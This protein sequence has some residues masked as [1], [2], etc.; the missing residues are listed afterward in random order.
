MV[1]NTPAVAGLGVVARQQNGQIAEAELAEGLR[2]MRGK[3][4]TRPR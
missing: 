3:D 4:Q 2:V 1:L